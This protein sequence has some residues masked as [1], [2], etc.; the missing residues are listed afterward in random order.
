MAFEGGLKTS[1]VKLCSNIQIWFILQKKDSNGFIIAVFSMK[2]PL[3]S[4]SR[5]QSTEAIEYAD[6]ASAKGCKHPNMCPG[7]D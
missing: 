3:C 7:Y 4:F 5:A 2:C 1:V 6:Y